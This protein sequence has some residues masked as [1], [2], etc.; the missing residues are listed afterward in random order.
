MTDRDTFPI[1]ITDIDEAAQYFA[2]K[3]K[4][5]GTWDDMLPT[6]V[7][8]FIQ[9]IYAGMAVGHQHTLLMTARNAY[10]KTAKRDSA[11]FAITRDLGVYVERSTSAGTTAVMTNGYPSTM[12]VTP[13]SQHR[14][15]NVKFY[16]PTQYFV[17]SGMTQTVDLL[18]GEVRTKEFDL[19]A[20]LNLSLH[21][22][23]L[24]EPGFNVTRDLLVYTTDKNTGNVTNWNAVDNGMF[25]YAADDRI[26]FHNTTASGDVSLTFGDGEYGQQ[27]PKKSTLTIRY[28][29]SEGSKHNAILPGVKTVYNDYPMVAGE[30]TDTTTGGADPKD[31]TYYR[32]YAPVAYRSKKKK[33]SKEEIEGAIRGYPGVADCVVLGQ[34]D[35][36][37]E[38]KTWMNTMR[39]CILPINT[40]SW[41]G[42]NPNPKSASWQNF[43]AWLEPQLHDRLETQTWNA[44]KV[45][46][47]V[48]VNI[49][50]FE[51]AADKADSIR[52]TVNENILKLFMKRAGILKRRVSKS[53]IEKACRI[54]GVDY[55][56]VISPTER[57]VVLGD[58]TSYCV[59]S[60]APLID[61]VISERVDE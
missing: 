50:I 14:V 30:T 33:I 16:N 56:E 15:G 61:M 6:N 25:E 3:L 53:D 8:S 59:L 48:H 20:I 57:S 28:I 32:Q 35:I 60:E 58:P 26:Y 41:G 37:P 13:Y 54:D 9:R 7:G 34:R 44:T 43:L 22:F 29:Y 19:D 39:V 46:V 11:I 21:E 38:D 2:E 36:A 4:E 5:E 1:A 27:L 55:I 17:I 49:A 47:F 24:E 10:L 40:D 23:L 42:A 52:N 31:A 18:Q 51:W 45:F 12:F